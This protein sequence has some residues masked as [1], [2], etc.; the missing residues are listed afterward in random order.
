MCD[1]PRGKFDVL[2]NLRAIEVPG[3]ETSISQLQVLIDQITPR[4]PS[5]RLDHRFLIEVLPR[6]DLNQLVQDLPAL[7]SILDWCYGADVT[8]PH[9]AKAANISGWEERLFDLPVTEA[10]YLSFTLSRF[11]PEDHRAW[12]SMNRTRLISFF[13]YHSRTVTA[14]EE[15]GEAGLTIRITFPVDWATP[16][17]PPHEQATSRLMVL[18]RLIPYYDVYESQGIHLLNE[19]QIVPY[20]DTFK[21]WDRTSIWQELDTEKNGAWIRRCENWYAAD[22]LTT[23]L[24]RWNIARQLANKVI[25]DI[26][27]FHIGTSDPRGHLEALFETIN[28]LEDVLR[29]LPSL[30]TSLPDELRSQ[31]KRQGS[32]WVSALNNFLT[33]WPSQ[34]R[35]DSDNRYNFLVRHNL[36]EARNALPELHAALKEVRSIAGEVG[37]TPADGGATEDTARYQE[38]ADTL[39]FTYDRDE[40]LP[41]PANQPGGVLGMITAWA[42]RRE[43][44]IVTAAI[45]ALREQEEQGYTF[46]HP[47]RLVDEH[48][49][50]SL[51]IGVII[52]DF[53]RVLNDVEVVLERL[54]RTQ[55]ETENLTVTYIEVLPLLPGRRSYDCRILRVAVDTLHQLL[56]GQVPDQMWLF[57]QEVTLDVKSVLPG[58]VYDPLPELAL[59]TPFSDATAA[60]M[61]QR[62]LIEVIETSLNPAETSD[63]SWLDEIKEQ[64]PLDKAITSMRESL[65]A[66]HSFE[67]SDSASEEAWRTIIA[68]CD[69]LIE[70]CIEGRQSEEVR[71]LFGLLSEFDRLINNY[72]NA[73]YLS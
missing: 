5:H 65:G 17:E 64:R 62:R 8:L 18:H 73:S 7:S 32:N 41:L 25:K 29:R 16:S 71:T 51:C 68:Y 9:L 53:N 39:D 2:Q 56:Q 14:V 44:R 52:D 33:Q 13:K 69:A 50:R 22:S 63:S 60:Y 72:L 66:L 59:L 1:S 42:R 26:C 19:N 57:P 27:R 10:S 11:V 54:G 31:I 47:I 37:R 40:T 49:L 35:N 6:I 15:N 58:V 36:K 20:D 21:Q 24:D 28:E 3:S 4:V 48:P 70:R 12:V 34:D 55:L 43:Q 67:P 61:R 30:P 46:V 38:L 45:T 23:W